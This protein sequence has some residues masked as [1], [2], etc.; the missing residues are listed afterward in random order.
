MLCLGDDSYRESLRKAGISDEENMARLK[1]AYFFEKQGLLHTEQDEEEI[2][3]ET[4]NVVEN[5][6]SVYRDLQSGDYVLTLV[7]IPEEKE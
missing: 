7:M 4:R 2:D 5:L 3:H 6:R 1:N